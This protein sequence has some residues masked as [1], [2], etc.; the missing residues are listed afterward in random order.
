MEVVMKVV[1]VRKML[2]SDPVPVYDA[3]SPKH[4]NLTLANGCVVHNT[5]KLARFKD[6]QATFKLKGKPLNVMEASKDQILKNTELAALFAGIGLEL[7][8]KAPLE[9]LKFGRIIYLADP[10]VDGKH[11]HTLLDTVFW[12]FTP[13]LF[14]R[15]QIFSVVSPEYMAKH[16]GKMLFGSS[17]ESLYKKA[18]TTKL[19]VQ[20]IKGWAEIEAPEMRE[21]AFDIGKRK[22]L[23]IMPPKD[24]KGRKEFESL[25][26]KDPTFRKKLLG[27]T[28]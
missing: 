17:K 19:D 11:I 13:E 1:S 3:T 21:I 10:D 18:G 26:G 9:G 15:G 20:H 25:M 14:K 24:A 2:L 6:F 12:K 8:R 28:K 27:V 23:R 16:K 5:A 4:H 22:L 7:S